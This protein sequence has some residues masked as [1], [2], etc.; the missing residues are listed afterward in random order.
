MGEKEI[1]QFLTHPPKEDN[2]IHTIQKL[3]D[4]DGVETTMT[5]AH[6]LQQRRKLKTVML[7]V[8]NEP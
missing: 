2:D 5:H 6:N 8:E 7:V 3:T 1:N 4:H